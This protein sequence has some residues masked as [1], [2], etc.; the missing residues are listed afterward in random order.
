MASN[1][2]GGPTPGDPNK[3]QDKVQGPQHRRIEKVEKVRE[4][5]EVE[6]EQTRKKFRSFLEEEE[7]PPPRIPSPFESDFYFTTGQSGGASALGGEAR[8]EEHTSE[9]QSQ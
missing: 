3:G 9:L 4:V 8:S 2:I 6:N 5:D 1:R 7:D